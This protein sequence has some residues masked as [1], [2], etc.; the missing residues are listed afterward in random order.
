MPAIASGPRLANHCIAYIGRIKR[1]KRLD[2]LVRALVAL[3]DEFPDIH[4]DIAGD[5]DARAELESLVKSLNISDHVTIHGHVDEETKAEILRSACVFATPSMQ[6]GWGLSV[7]EANA[8]GCPA[9]AYN[10]SGLRISIVHGTTGLLAEDDQQFRESIAS[11]LRNS[12]LRDRL[13][14]AAVEWARGFSWEQCAR[15]T[16]AIMFEVSREGATNRI[17]RGNEIA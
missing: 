4:L 16:L 6:E 12:E 8:Y 17:P 15:Q 3:R 1:Y 14:T 2:R 9:V 5:G 10:V 13:G 11:L 7:I